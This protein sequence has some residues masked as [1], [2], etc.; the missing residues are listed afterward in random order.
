MREPTWEPIVTASK[1]KRG[2]RASIREVPIPRWSQPW[3]APLRRW[4]CHACAG[5][6]S[7][8]WLLSL[9]A[10]SAPLLVLLGLVALLQR[11]GPARLQTLPALAI[12]TGLLA[13]SAARRRQS[14][15]RILIALREDGRA[16]GGSRP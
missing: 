7:R 10:L 8:R 15:R 2:R 9:L 16:T 14:R 4:W 1:V 11:Q 12:G 13:T 3:M 5:V 6:M